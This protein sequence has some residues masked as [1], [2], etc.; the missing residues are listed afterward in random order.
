[1]LFRSVD[2][3]GV[4]VLH[5]DAV[6]ADILTVHHRHGAGTPCD[7]LDLGVDLEE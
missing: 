5:G 2:G 4:A 7:A 1:M 6:E 3:P